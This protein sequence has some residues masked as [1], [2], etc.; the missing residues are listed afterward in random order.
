[1]F[2]IFIADKVYIPKELVPDTSLL[3]KYW[4]FFVFDE[5]LCSKCDNKPLRVNQ[6]CRLCPGLQKIIR[7]WGQKTAANGQE[8]YTL[9]AGQISQ[10][11]LKLNIS[12]RNNP[13]IVIEDHR[14]DKGFDHDLVFTGK[15]RTGEAVN[16]IATANQQYLVNKW[17]EVGSG[18]I[19]AP[20]RTGKTVIGTYLSCFLQK[21]TLITAHQEE[22]LQNF[23][24]TYES[25]TNLNELRRLSG[26]QIV[27]VVTKIEDLNN[28]YYDVILINYQKFIRE[29]SGD[30][31][32]N[33]YLKNKYSFVAVDECH[34]AGA[35]CFSKFLNKLNPKYT[36][37]LSATPKRKDCIAG[38]HLI[39]TE[40]GLLSIEE[41]CN[42]VKRGNSVRV[43]SQNLQTGQIEL[44][45]VL[46][47]HEV[48][49][50][51]NKELH[52][53]NGYSIKCTQDHVL[54]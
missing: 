46:E 54:Y 12:V 45:K 13:N 40:W 11:F 8:F 4:E 26:K 28:E 39:H 51:Q 24:K 50:T 2:K 1:M 25:M 7:M 31:R 32:I 10:I 49:S 43:Y 41:V 5:P 37:G 21:K 42:L 53:E 22:L 47:C 35:E 16:G 18:I 52:L 3:N 20:P 9:P 30:D 48:M 6:Q 33:A 34:Q 29:Q 27:K 15:L 44:K 38:N 17:L 14:C 23:Y 36:L 19:E